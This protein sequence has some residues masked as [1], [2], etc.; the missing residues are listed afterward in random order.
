[1]LETADKTRAELRKDFITQQAM[2][3]QQ[4]IDH[5]A[6]IERH[7]AAIVEL[8]KSRAAVAAGIAALAAPAQRSPVEMAS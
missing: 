2:I 8:G 1:M 3:D 6:E 7:K 5:Q 4:I